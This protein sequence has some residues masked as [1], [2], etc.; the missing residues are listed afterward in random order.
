[1]VLDVRRGFEGVSQVQIG[2]RVA[3]SK[4]VAGGVVGR[5]LAHAAIAVVLPIRSG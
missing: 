3:G 4:R 1:M 5:L 2:R